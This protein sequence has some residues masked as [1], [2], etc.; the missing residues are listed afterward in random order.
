VGDALHLHAPY[1]VSDIA[2]SGAHAAAAGVHGAL[3]PREALER[4]R[5]VAALIVRDEVKGAPHT[6]LNVPI[7]ATRRY[8]IVRA[9][10]T[11]LKAIGRELGGSV[12]DVVL[13]A[14]AAGLR[15]LLLSRHEQP[16]PEGADCD[17]TPDFDVLAAG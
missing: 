12:N 5:T 2:L 10:L 9:S 14:C 13:T 7:G 11:E 16:P 6:S 15:R 3:H 8:D 1:A 4:S 17:S